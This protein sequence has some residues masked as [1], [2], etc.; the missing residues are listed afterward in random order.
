M[1]HV[2]CLMPLRAIRY[3]LSAILLFVVILTAFSQPTHAKKG[4]KH[5]VL[6]TAS[7]S[8]DGLPFLD[9]LSGEV[10]IDGPETR[11][12]QTFTCQGGMGTL[13][14]VLIRRGMADLQLTARQIRPPGP[15]S[16]IFDLTGT[17]RGPSSQ[18]WLVL[19]GSGEN[20]LLKLRGKS[21]VVEIAL[22]HTTLQADARMGTGETELSIHSA[23][24]HLQLELHGRIQ[25][26]GSPLAGFTGACQ[27]S[28]HNIDLTQAPKDRLDLGG[29]LDK[30]SLTATGN[31]GTLA[32]S[33]RLESPFV[34]ADGTVFVGLTE[35][36]SG[37]LSVHARREAVGRRLS[38]PWMNFIL[39]K[40]LSA[41]LTLGGTRREPVI[42]AIEWKK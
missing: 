8:I 19:E 28:L 42:S 32:V 36:I 12:N 38:L 5:L 11:I 33:L 24:E 15:L 40:E 16:G 23:G 20:L 29:R 39:Q 27:F 25:R 31:G 7:V 10:I 3:P 22:G 2:S 41:I 34:K 18:R 21:G 4:P 26:E 13:E 14:G 9:N 30:L 6:H 1:S 17:V 37:K 35:Q